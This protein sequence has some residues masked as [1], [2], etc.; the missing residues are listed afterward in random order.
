MKPGDLVRPVVPKNHQN[1]RIRIYDVPHVI[2]EE[3]VYPSVVGKMEEGSTG[4][5]LEMD[6]G[7]VKVLYGSTIGWV[8]EN[9]LEVV[10]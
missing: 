6:E 1:P 4:L 10:E 7:R 2:V 9:L 5:V 8:R 3:K